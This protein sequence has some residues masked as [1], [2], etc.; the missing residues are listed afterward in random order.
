MFPAVAR[1]AAAPNS[2]ICVGA[3]LLFKLIRTMHIRGS[4]AGLFSAVANSG[5]SQG[6]K[7]PA[8]RMQLQFWC[9]CLL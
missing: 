7:T 1:F 8:V 5:L 3:C 6:E 9:G 2:K 4:L